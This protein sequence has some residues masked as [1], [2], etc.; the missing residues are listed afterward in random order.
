MTA[1]TGGASVQTAT[2]VI[3]EN[4]KTFRMKNSHET[5]IAAGIKE[6]IEVILQLLVVYGELPAMPKIEVTVDFDDSIA[7]DR[8]ANATYYSGLV[9]QGLMPKVK[10]I[11]RIFDLPEEEA[12]KW[13][14]EI[15]QESA[16]AT[17]AAIDLFGTNQEGGG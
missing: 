9:A 1:F 7:E 12:R 17:A 15:Q 11:M 2:Q 16:T 8:Q 13:L 10:A 4:S 5:L 3:S 14:E 6:L